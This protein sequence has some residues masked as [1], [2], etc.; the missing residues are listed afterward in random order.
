MERH[1]RLWINQ[2]ITEHIWEPEPT[3]VNFICSKVLAGR[4]PQDKLG[5]MQM[6]S[7]ILHS[8]PEYCD[9]CVKVSVCSLMQI[10]NDFQNCLLGQLFYTAV[11]PRRQF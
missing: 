3:L 11:H 8:I 2:N 1:I 10:L 7:Y 9:M 6:V 4:A 5:S